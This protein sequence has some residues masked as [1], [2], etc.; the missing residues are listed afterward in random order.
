[1]RRRAGAP[2]RVGT[3]DPARGVQERVGGLEILIAEEMAFDALPNV[4]VML[5]R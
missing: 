4:A 3:L 2:V 1:M 5:H